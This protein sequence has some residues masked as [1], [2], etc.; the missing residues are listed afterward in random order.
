MRIK[1]ILVE[2]LLLVVSFGLAAA[3]EEGACKPVVGLPL[4]GQH[5]GEFLR[6]A[7]IVGTPEPFD[8]VAIT[9]PLRVTLTDG[10]RTLRAIFKDEDTLYPNF[11]FGDGREVKRVRDSYKHE[12]A[13]FQLDLLLDLGVVPPC[14]E[15]K[16]D[17]RTGSLCL[18]IES[19]RTEDKRR[20]EGLVPPDPERFINDSREVR[21]FQQ[22]IADLDY[23]NIRNLV[24]DDNFKVY[25][26]DSSMAFYPDPRLIRE[27]DSSHVS[28]RFLD[29][30]RSLEQTV[31]DER[32]EP[33][34][35][36]A[37]LK[38]LVKRRERILERVDRLI[39]EHGEDEVLY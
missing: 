37:E 32:L 3:G 9:S 26:V 31:L 22:L 1:L 6:S 4:T 23:S 5:A 30:L 39:A 16:I 13:A 21:L 18:W 28:R 14:V 35:T 20:E 36:K 11:R 17:S 12:I 27:L 10:D 34:L 38:D 29:A 33:W 19:S 2:S 8:P 7:R 15:R 24:V 25:K